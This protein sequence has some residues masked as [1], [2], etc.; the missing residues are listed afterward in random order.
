MSYNLFP[1]PTHAAPTS[2][3]HTSLLP[4]VPPQL[5]R[6]D[7]KIHF[8]EFLAAM[9]DATKLIKRR[10]SMVLRE[11]EGLDVD[12]DGYITPQ[13]LVMASKAPEGAILPGEGG[14]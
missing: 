12:H 7:S 4:L 11:F 6:H 14:G 5:D 2:S 9:S 13:D 10:P 3:P 1:P 8:E